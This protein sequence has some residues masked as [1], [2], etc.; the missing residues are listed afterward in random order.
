[1]R[2]AART[3]AAVTLRL[4]ETIAVIL[5][6]ARDATF[7]ESLLRHAALV[8][9]G[10]QE[11]LPSASDRREAAERYIAIFGELRSGDSGPTV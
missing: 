3:N 9:E 10:G 7:R 4:L 11:G 1:I 8:H 5:P 6:F 2:Q